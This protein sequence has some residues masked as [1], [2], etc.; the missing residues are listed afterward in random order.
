M[1]NKKRFVL[2]ANETIDQ[3]LDRIEK[4]G[5]R[6]VRKME[7]PIFKEIDENGEKTVTPIGKSIIFDTIRN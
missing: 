5:Y 4:E 6:P 7:E 1:S 3:C 2:Q